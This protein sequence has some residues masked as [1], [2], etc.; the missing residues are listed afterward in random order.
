METTGNTTNNSKSKERKVV[1]IELKTDLNLRQ[2][3]N[4]YQTLDH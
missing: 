4:P 1:K 2:T 3:L